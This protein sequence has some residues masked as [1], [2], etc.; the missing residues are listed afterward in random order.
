[1]ARRGLL[2]EED[3]ALELL[4]SDSET[5]AL[6]PELVNDSDAESWKG[7]L[8][9]SDLSSDGASDESSDSEEEELQ[10]PVGQTDIPM[11]ASDA[12]HGPDEEPTPAKQSRFLEVDDE[13][14]FDDTEMSDGFVSLESHRQT[15]NTLS[16]AIRLS[17]KTVRDNELYTGDSD[18]SDDDYASPLTPSQLTLPPPTPPPLSSPLITP[19][20]PTPTPPPLTPPPPTPPPPT[21]PPP[22]PALTTGSD[23]AGPSRITLEKAV[24]KRRGAP[25][26]LTTGP[27]KA[28]PSSLSLKKAVTQ[29]AP[30][31]QAI[32]PP[33]PVTLTTG[34]D[35]AG[36]SVQNAP[37]PRRSARMRLR[38]EAL[39]LGEEYDDE[40][41]RDLP[42][43][44]TQDNSDQVGGRRFE[45]RRIYKKR[46]VKSIDTALD[47]A[48]YNPVRYVW[49]NQYVIMLSTT[50][51]SICLL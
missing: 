43:Q 10:V 6:L 27:V 37:K 18:S 7:A 4:K 11:G 42:G 20:P 34:S 16:Q 24:R 46:I 17:L 2:K 8:S 25:T 23:K 30:T 50:V 9:N 15:T 13:F 12:V 22:P 38:D 26:T 19:P 21:P 32:P 28:G 47:P 39:A 40:Q 33:P 29:S 1:M 44:E 51:I 5:D 36:P 45:R 3:I 49:Y 41:V 31:P 35:E 14:D 48:N